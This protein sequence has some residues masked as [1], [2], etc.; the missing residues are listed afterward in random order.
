V[1]FF[2]RY[3]F[4]IVMVVFLVG[5]LT[6]FSIN[7]NRD[8]EETISGRLVLEL[9]GPLQQAASSLGAAISALWNHYFNLVHTARLNEELKKEIAGLRL[10]LTE[11]EELRQENLRLGALL[12]LQA[13][14]SPPQTAAMVVGWDA[15]NN[16]RTAIINKGANHGVH[17]QMAVINSQ[18]V[19]GRVVWSSPNYAK[20]LLLI[21]SNSAI[22]VLVQRSRA[23]GIVEGAGDDKLR[24]KYIMH[25]DE[26]AVGDL[27]IASGVEGVFPKGA[28]V[29]KVRAI[30]HE[31]VD[32]FLTI[33][34]EPAVAFERLE[35]VAV[36]MQRRNLDN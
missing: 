28:L 2:R 11:L 32:M 16:F 35:E 19:V 8:P 26:V 13:P 23:R 22:D 34:L 4:I 30:N 5:S 25:A 12:K 20:I 17:S 15:S 14:N 36:I 10:Q 21:D 1:N 9:T 18:G 6:I 27:I 7:A 29:G 24:L 31:T 33:E 3:F